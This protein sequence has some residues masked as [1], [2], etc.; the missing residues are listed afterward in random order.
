MR[1]RY[2][3]PALLLGVGLTLMASLPS[4]AGESVDKEKIAKLIDQLG[5]GAFAERQKATKELAAIGA[6]A[7]EAL[8]KAAQS[9]DAEVRKRANELVRKI[10]KEVVSARLLAPKRIHLVYKD[11]LVSKA[12]ADFRK[13]SGYN[14]HLHDP[15]G[16]LKARTITLDTGATTFWHAYEMFCEK[17]GLTEAT[18]QEL[19][20]APAPAGGP[21]GGP[22]PPQRVQ[23]KKGAPAAPV[24]P[25]PPPAAKKPEAAPPPAPAVAPAVA[26]PGAR[27]AVPFAPAGAG[28]LMLKDG[29]AEKLPTDD[30]CAVRVRARPKADLFGGA[31]QGEI[32]LA[33][34][35]WP[36]PRL[37]WQGLQ[38]IRIDKARDNRDQTWTQ[39]IPQTPAFP[40]AAG[41]PQQ[42]ERW[43]DGVKFQVPVQFKK[44]NKAAKS[45]AELKGVL[46]AQML[47][48]AKPMI[49][50]DNLAKAA[51]KT[52]KG[53]EGG[54]IKILTVKSEEKR[55]TIQLEFEQPA[56]TV[57]AT[58]PAGMPGA[59]VP[60][61]PAQQGIKPL[62]APA[63]QPLAP[64]V[65][66]PPP[67]PP[68]PPAAQAPAGKPQAA[69]VQVQVQGGFAA[70]AIA[71]PAFAGPV[72]GLSVQDAKG[73]TLAVR[74]GPMQFRMVQGAGG[75][76]F[77]ATYTLLCEP[78]K[79]QGEPAKVVYLGRKRV[80]VDVPFTLKD[81]PLP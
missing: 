52:F 61:P 63:V 7:L 39:V 77:V 47:T 16:K 37:A 11:T 50:A 69:Q 10:E 49:T 35:V 6:P 17:A 21:P 24:L 68:P 60:A 32:L 51:G 29:K 58:P 3:L 5:S 44:G 9:E 1:N 15:E 13:K 18:I 55:T 33:L 36:E 48:E 14:I 2:L 42:I 45:L 75:N 46:T 79:E 67:L 19:M 12:V 25:A 40:G 76:V 28:W 72:N 78:G 27:I 70:G 22:A 56:D 23:P 26:R 20:R 73:N 38:S 34:E 65:V 66:P 54:Y 71:A 64:P 41:G 8:R 62:P 31:P 4:P 30:R 80:T 81:V 57:P 53:E 43:I 74:M 59:A